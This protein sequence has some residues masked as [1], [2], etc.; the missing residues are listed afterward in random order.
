MMEKKTEL[1]DIKEFEEKDWRGIFAAASLLIFIISMLF[2]PEHLT[3]AS[4][5]SMMA[6]SYYFTGTE[7]KK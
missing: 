1:M 3:E 7:V 6:L 2:R 5:L 4:A